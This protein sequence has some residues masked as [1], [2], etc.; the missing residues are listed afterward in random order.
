MAWDEGAE[1]AVWHR[2]QAGPQ[3]VFKKCEQGLEGQLLRGGS[4]SHS[5][6]PWDNGLSLPDSNTGC[7]APATPLPADR[8]IPPAEPWRPHGPT[9]DTS[10]GRGAEALPEM[11]LGKPRVPEPREA[12]WA[13]FGGRPGHT[14]G[15]WPPAH[16][17]PCCPLSM[18]SFPPHPPAHFRLSL[19]CETA[20]NRGACPPPPT[21]TEGL[22]D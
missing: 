10:R 18:H 5:P 7:S 15:V 4:L 22:R 17:C 6:A 8:A 11:A 14:A 12:G 9:G 2:A 20:R 1:R 21:H 13:W 16:G 19:V 3:V